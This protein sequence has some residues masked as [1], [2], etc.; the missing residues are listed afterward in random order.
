MRRVDWNR[1]TTRSPDSVSHVSGMNCYP[2]VRNGPQLDGCGGRQSL[3]GHSHMKQGLEDAKLQCPV[4]LP[5]VSDFSPSRRMAA[6][7]QPS[8]NILSRFRR[9]SATSAP[10]FSLADEP[11]VGT[12][13][14]TF[15]R[16]SILTL[17]CEAEVPDARLCICACTGVENRSNATT[18]RDS[19]HPSR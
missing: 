19:G 4:V 16:S 1:S 14:A 2:C 5:R 7:R 12:G 15:P 8:S 10:T 17:L 11:S 18:Y 13:K 9:Y 3:V 6:S